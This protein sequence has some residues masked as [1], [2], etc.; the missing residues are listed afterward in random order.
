V[1]SDFLP[2]RRGYRPAITLLFVGTI[3]VAAFRQGVFQS[4]AHAGA[5]EVTAGQARGET[6]PGLNE[7]PAMKP[8]DLAAEQEALERFASLGLPIYC[9]GGTK[10]YVAL[11]FDDGPGPY[12][13]QTLNLLRAG[14]A[15]ATFFSVGKKLEYFPDVP[16]L[17]L[18]AGAIGNHTWTHRDMRGAT[19]QE[20]YEE[21]GRTRA[22]LAGATGAPVRMFRPPY[23]AHDAALDQ[24]VRSLGMAEIMWS[25]ESGDSAGAPPSV[26]LANTVAGLRPGAIILMHENRGST[27]SMLPQIL[28]AI[29]DKGLQAVTVPYMLANDPPSE[30]QLRAGGGCGVS[31]TIPPEQWSTT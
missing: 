19:A 3:A 7:L 26:V 14:G 1:R 13:I 25:A 12:T 9:G 17:E 23:G 10:P 11:T 28:Q 15:R 27:L 5:N 16:S 21:V 31:P 6:E 30:A 2:R 18:G 4:L 29:A 24:Y 20:L 8:Q 22:E